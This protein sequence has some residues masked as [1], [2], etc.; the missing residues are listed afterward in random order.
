MDNLERVARLPWFASLAEPLRAA[1]IARG[2]FRRRPA[3]AWLYGEGDEDTGIAV[4]LEG[5][6]QVYAQASGGREVFF[7]LMPKDSVIG[8]SVVF[9]GGPR[10]VTAVCGANTELFLLDDAALRKTATEFP[11]LHASY[12]ALLY[13]QLRATAQVVAD[14]VALK[15]RGRLISRLLA[16][17]GPDGRV[18]LSQA[19]LAELVGV[20][21]KT[22][23]GWL[24][25]LQ[26]AG[27][28]RLG[29]GRIELL[30]PDGLRRLLELPD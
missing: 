27:K 15:P 25:R 18:M 28:L 17:A 3:G 12:S 1:L 23:N 29:Y 13:E 21:R 10:I 2:R 4:V 30:D 14:I 8:Q 11:D 7:A 5:A 22:A 24:A 16:S 6:L 19:A 26:R 20:S 9:G